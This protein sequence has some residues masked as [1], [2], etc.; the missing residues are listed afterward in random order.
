MGLIKNFFVDGP[1]L[2]SAI[3]SVFVIVVAVVAVIVA[4]VVAVVS[5]DIVLTWRR[6]QRHRFHEHCY[7][8]GV[9]G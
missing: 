8:A 6:T 3:A 5:V 9:C 7:C 4:V 1:C 2:S